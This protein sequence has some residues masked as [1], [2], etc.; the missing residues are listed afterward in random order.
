MLWLIEFK[1]FL[2]MTSK[3]QIDFS[4]IA[5][6]NLF[7]IEISSSATIVLVDAYLSSQLY[8]MKLR[9]TVC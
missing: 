7:W 9:D 2:P 4:D 6:T 1:S 8:Y 3:E 5:P